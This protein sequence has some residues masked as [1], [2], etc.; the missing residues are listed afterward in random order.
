[1]CTNNKKI[2]NYVPLKVCTGLNVFFHLIIIRLNDGDNYDVAQRNI[3]SFIRKNI[4]I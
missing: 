2:V 1:M 4:I 3:E